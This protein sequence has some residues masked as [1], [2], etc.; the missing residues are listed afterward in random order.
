MPTTDELHAAD[1]ALEAAIEEVRRQRAQDLEMLQRHDAE[2][3]DNALWRKSIDSAVSRLLAMQALA[4]KKSDL[5][6][7]VQTLDTIPAKAVGW[8]LGGFALIAV[9]AIIALAMK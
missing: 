7:A 8:F 3:A 1:Q 4:A 6:S 5:D 2:L 9:A